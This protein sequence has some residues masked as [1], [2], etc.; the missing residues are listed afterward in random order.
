MILKRLVG[1]PEAMIAEE[2][3]AVNE[4]AEVEECSM[5]ER[6][7]RLRMVGLAAAATVIRALSM[8]RTLTMGHHNRTLAPDSMEAILSHLSRP[9]AMALDVVAAVEEAPTDL[10]RVE[11]LQVMAALRA[12]AVADQAMVAEATVIAEALLGTVGLLRAMVP[13]LHLGMEVM[14]DT[15]LLRLLH[16]TITAAM[17]VMAVPLHPP[18]VMGVHTTIRVVHHVVVGEVDNTRSPDHYAR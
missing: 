14:E 4:V 15:A 18:V 16:E 7:T 5:A 9:M 2:D 17:E 11:V 3:H 10:H 6:V 12:T 8:R 1:K 13:V